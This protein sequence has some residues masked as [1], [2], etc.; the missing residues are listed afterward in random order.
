MYNIPHIFLCTYLQ[1]PTF[2]IIFNDK[3]GKNINISNFS[4]RNKVTT[5]PRPYSRHHSKNKKKYLLLTT[6]K[7]QKNIYF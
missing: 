7:W 5:N 1:F 3:R 6:E 4:W 2:Q